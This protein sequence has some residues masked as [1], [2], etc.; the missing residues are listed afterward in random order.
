M[1]RRQ[2]EWA[3]ASREW[4]SRLVAACTSSTYRLTLLAVE[5]PVAHG[6]VPHLGA[7]RPTRRKPMIHLGSSRKHCGVMLL[8]MITWRRW[9]TMLLALCHRRQSAA[10]SSAASLLL[11]PASRRR[12]LLQLHL[13]P[14][15]LCTSPPT[16]GVGRGSCGQLGA[17]PALPFAI[18]ALS[19]R[20]QGA[21]D[22][23]F[24][25]LGGTS[26]VGGL[27][28]CRSRHPLPACAPT[29]PCP[30]SPTL[31]VVAAAHIKVRTRL[32][33]QKLKD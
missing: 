13:G 14:C 32:H 30:C 5:A 10:A 33:F 7:V 23:E 25:P 19:T 29:A 21:P 17:A 11:P 8:S 16:S 20:S 22:E 1:G 6:T 31:S 27:Q 18:R 2:G 3:A 9:L 26:E 24:A 15:W 4:A 28:I 12:P